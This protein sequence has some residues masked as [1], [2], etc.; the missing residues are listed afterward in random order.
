VRELAAVDARAVSRKRLAVPQGNSASL[1]ATAAS[2][3]RH[4]AV[5]IVHLVAAAYRLFRH[6]AAVRKKFGVEPK[7]SSHRRTGQ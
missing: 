2:H 6:A 4:N 1:A 5:M 7:P 3:A